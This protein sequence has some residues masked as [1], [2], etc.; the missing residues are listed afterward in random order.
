VSNI[1]SI[2]PIRM[3]LLSI[4]GISLLVAG[5]GIMNT[6][7]MSVIER[8]REIGILKAIGT[9][10]ARI[11]YAFMVESGLVGAIG[12]LGGCALGILLLRVVEFAATTYQRTTS[13]PIPISIK[14]VISGF[15]FALTSA[16]IFGLYPSWKAST[17]K[18]VEALRYE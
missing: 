3:F 10:K 15:L 17:L 4:A 14:A 18:P 1:G 13:E 16:T 5:L 8:K 11:I 6:M 7:L 12:G 2:E 9:S